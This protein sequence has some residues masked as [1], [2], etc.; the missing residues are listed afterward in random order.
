MN[1]PPPS[2]NQMPNMLNK[3]PPVQH[4]ITKVFV[5]NIS[6]RAPDSMIRQMLQRCG[7]VLSWKR[8]EGTNGKLQAF[9]FC[10][11]AEP[12]YT[13]RCIRL[14]NGYEIADKKL[15]VKVDQKTRELLGEFIRRNRSDKAQTKNARKAA[16]LRNI[17]GN[18]IRSGEE[19]E[20]LEDEE[21]PKNINLEAVDEDT[22][23][24]DR[25]TI[26][27]LELILRQFASDL[28]P[29][30]EGKGDEEE[31][32]E[33][34]VEAEPAAKVNEGSAGEQQ[35]D[36]DRLVRDG[37]YMKPHLRLE[38]I[39]LDDEKK[40]LMTNE[41]SKFRETHKV[42]GTQQRILQTGV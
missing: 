40:E 1:R 25:S 21:D 22:L 29:P 13:L 8:V 17:R 30:V 18:I 42:R 4:P 23:K 20:T 6:E 10:D 41:I 28:E 39:K 31:F 15:M 34:T 19:G 32:E 27:A 5:G 36:N 14:L 2:F 37:I 38:E 35:P 9:G 12:Q 16:A 26:G 24:E 33:A 7:S 11:F 3:P